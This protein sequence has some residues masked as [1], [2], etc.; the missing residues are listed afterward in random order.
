MIKP[1]WFSTRF[2]N[3][4]DDIQTLDQ[5]LLGQLHEFKSIPGKVKLI[6]V[7]T[8]KQRLIMAIKFIWLGLII[9]NQNL[10]LIMVDTVDVSS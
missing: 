2:T 9:I 7:E 8:G 1:C 4:E 10:K 6:I 3:L 5:V